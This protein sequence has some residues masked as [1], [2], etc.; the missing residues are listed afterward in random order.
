[1][2]GSLLEPLF[3]DSIA[4]GATGC[5]G[6]VVVTGSHAGRFAAL[7]AAKAGVRAVIFNDASVG[8]DAAGIAG[9][10]LL[11]ESEIAGAAVDAA[12]AEIGRASSTWSEGIISHANLL[13]Q[14]LGVRAGMSCQDAANLLAD[15]EIGDA[16][17]LDT[18]E[19]RL[20]LNKGPPPMWALDSAS[21]VSPQ[22]AGAILFLGSH[23]GLLGGRPESA[24][25]AP[26]RAAVYND[27]GMSL[28]LAGVSRLPALD[29]R[30]IAAAT[31]SAASARIGDGR[32]TYEDGI[33]SAVNGHARQ[34]GAYIGM[35]SKEFAVLASAIQ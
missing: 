14:N 34:A 10:S 19:A 4:S 23:G 18:A 16:H 17:A 5:R 13:A 31:V 15:A 30:G 7:C 8:R 28:R 33:I 2:N 1:M 21:L 26:A 6:R 35:T 3:L 29:Q 24:L 20:L 12:S 11:E 32:S 22:D 25:K 9:L 27:A